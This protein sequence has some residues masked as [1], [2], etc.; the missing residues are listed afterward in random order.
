MAT[1]NEQKHSHHH[2]HHHHHHHSSGGAGKA[3]GVNT[4]KNATD[5]TSI[6]REKMASRNKR[7]KMLEHLLFMTLVCVCVLV[8]LMLI[9]AYV[10][11]R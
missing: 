6:F 5:A 11:D 10:V 8:M 7:K 2:H 9:F 1:E 3:L 4:H